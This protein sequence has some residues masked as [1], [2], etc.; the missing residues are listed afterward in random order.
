MCV[1]ACASLLSLALS[2]LSTYLHSHFRRLCFWASFPIILRVNPDTIITFGV[3]LGFVDKLAATF[4]FVTFSLLISSSSSV[5]LLSPFDLFHPILHSTLRNFQCG[6][7]LYFSFSLS[8]PLNLVTIVVGP[9]SSCNKVP[10]TALG[11]HIVSFPE[12]VPRKSF[13]SATIYI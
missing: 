13:L 11:G 1:F 3:H 12:Q 6:S 9:L 4:V 8:P 5:F 2:L 10:G 7:S